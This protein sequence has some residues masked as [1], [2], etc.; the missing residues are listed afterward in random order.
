MNPIENTSPKKAWNKPE[1][2]LISSPQGGSNQ[3]FH[4]GRVIG[5][6]SSAGMYLLKTAGGQGYLA[7]NTR[8]AYYS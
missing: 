2:L 5:T 7:A 8:H 4:E 6:G 1:I 3:T